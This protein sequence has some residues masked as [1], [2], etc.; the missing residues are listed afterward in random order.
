MFAIN[1]YECSFFVRYLFLELV[2][3]MSHDFEFPFHFGRF[4]LGF[5]QIFEVQVAIAATCLNALVIT[6]TCLQSKTYLIQSLLLFQPRFGF[7]IRAPI[8]L[9]KFYFTDFDSE[10]RILV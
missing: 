7:R 2:D 5:H 9:C 1:L 3:L 8:S 10:K 6:V 4:V